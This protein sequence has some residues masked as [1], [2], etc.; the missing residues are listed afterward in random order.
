MGT[1]TFSI[2]DEIERIFRETVARVYGAERGALSRA[3]EEAIMLWVKSKA[4]KRDKQVQFFA[5]LDDEII[6]EATSLEELAGKLKGMNIDPRSVIILSS[7]DL[8]GKRKERLGFRT[9][10]RG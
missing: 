7:E 5:K 1:V 6:A 8:S 3:I 4:E 2:K 9:M 10:K